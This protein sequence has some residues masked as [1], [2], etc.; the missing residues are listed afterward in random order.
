MCDQSTQI[1]VIGQLGFFI[2]NK[3]LSKLSLL[4]AQI[5]KAPQEP[6]RSLKSEPK[7]G[8]MIQDL[9]AHPGGEALKGFQQIEIIEEEVDQHN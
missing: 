5:P 1:G 8:H 4:L 2:T 3:K 6:P 9:S 7:P